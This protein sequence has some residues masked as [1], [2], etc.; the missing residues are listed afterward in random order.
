MV[1]TVILSGIFPQKHGSMTVDHTFF[2]ARLLSSLSIH[3]KLSGWWKQCLIA[4]MFWVITAVKYPLTWEAIAFD[5]RSYLLK[6]YSSTM[7]MS[8]MSLVQWPVKH[9]WPVWWICHWKLLKRRK[10]PHRNVTGLSKMNH[11]CRQQTRKECEAAAQ[12]SWNYE[13]L[14]VQITLQR[15]KDK[16]ESDL[17]SARQNQNILEARAAEN[18]VHCVVVLKQSMQI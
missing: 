3:L 5:M 17:R 12:Y 7:R 2:F 1:I 8:T 9:K 6:V 13:S 15:L 11:F 16:S 14:S 10:P 4:I 18:R